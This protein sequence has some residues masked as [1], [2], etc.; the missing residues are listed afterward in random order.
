MEAVHF[1]EMSIHFYQTSRCQFLKTV[2][3]IVITIRTSNLT[4]NTVTYT[5][6]DKKTCGDNLG[7][8]DIDGRIILDRVLRKYAVRMLT[9][10]VKAVLKLWFPNIKTSLEQLGNC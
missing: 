10:S 3:F 6:L 7:L 5:I 2:L 1:S 4:K 8:S 9:S